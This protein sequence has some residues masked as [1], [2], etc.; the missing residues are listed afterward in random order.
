RGWGCGAVGGGRGGL[1]GCA[2][3]SPSAC[4]GG[5][6]ASGGSPPTCGPR[7]TGSVSFPPAAKEDRSPRPGSPEGRRRPARIAET[8]GQ[9]QYGWRH[10]E[11]KLSRR[12]P[13]WRAMHHRGRTATPHPLFP[14]VAPNIRPP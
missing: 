14:L 7:P 13:K 11:K 3:T 5:T 4:A 8:K 2:E 1:G 9:L 10:L 6:T 12:D